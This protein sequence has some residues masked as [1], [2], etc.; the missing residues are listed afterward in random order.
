MISSFDFEHMDANRITLKRLESWGAQ[1]ARCSS[2]IGSFRF[3]PVSVLAESLAGFLVDEDLRLTACAINGWA[4]LLLHVFHP[5]PSA[6][7]S[8]ALINKKAESR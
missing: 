7:S 3:R 1:C 8:A 5:F 4:Q 6:I 2:A